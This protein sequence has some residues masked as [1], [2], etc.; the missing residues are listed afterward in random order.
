MTQSEL[1][2]TLSELYINN[3][4]LAYQLLERQTISSEQLDKILGNEWIPLSQLLR[5]EK[6]IFKPELDQALAEQRISRK[7]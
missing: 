5:Q 2:L 6:L 3:Q 7:K 4:K 1:D